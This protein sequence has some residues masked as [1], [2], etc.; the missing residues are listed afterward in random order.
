MSTI[1]KISIALTPD[2]ALL[3]RNTVESGFYT[4]NSEVICEALRDWGGQ[5]GREPTK[6]PGN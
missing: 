3:V 2:L 1:E 4:S 6:N 5:T